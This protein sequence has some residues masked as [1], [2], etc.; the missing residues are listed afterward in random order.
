[1]S[2]ANL[3][4]ASVYARTVLAC[5]S[6]QSGYINHL[7]YAGGFP[8]LSIG[9]IADV[10]HASAHHPFC[11][12]PGCLEYA[13]TVPK[14]LCSAQATNYLAIRL[15]LGN[16]LPDPRINLLSGPLRDFLKH[17]RDQLAHGRSIAA[18]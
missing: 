11:C 8:G 15:A 18:A 3:V 6:V 9:S 4:P 5:S 7:F 2:G 14:G 10:V 16:A 12:N 1:M 17:F 13:V